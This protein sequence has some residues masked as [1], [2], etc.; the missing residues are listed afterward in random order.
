MRH[1][2][3]VEVV[4]ASTSF[5]S[6][7]IYIDRYIYIDVYIYVYSAKPLGVAQFLYFDMKLS[8]SGTY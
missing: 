1:Y 7:A 6:N 3:K 2:L 5:Q 8:S 4:K